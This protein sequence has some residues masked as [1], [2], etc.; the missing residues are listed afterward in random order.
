M[1]GLK[2]LYVPARDLTS[3]QRFYSEFLGLEEIYTSDDQ[4][5]YA[6]NGFQFSIYSAPDAAPA[7]DEWATQPGWEGET[8]PLVSWSVELDE[9]AFV[10][11]VHAI[12]LSTSRTLYDKPQ[13]VGY[14]SFPVKDPMGNTV[15]ITWPPTKPP[16]SAGW[17]ERSG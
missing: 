14:W 7:P 17:A 5:A 4:V 6:C 12:R 16:R 10:N 9:A 8:V 15:E 11:A 13:W 3:M 2:F 1:T